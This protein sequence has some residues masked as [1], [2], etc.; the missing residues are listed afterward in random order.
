MKNLASIITVALIIFNALTT[1]FVV[2]L[3]IAGY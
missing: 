3:G 1:G 2:M